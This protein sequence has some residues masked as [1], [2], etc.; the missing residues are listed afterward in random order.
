MERIGN[1]NVTSVSN[2]S[3]VNVNEWV[4]SQR[5]KAKQRSQDNLANAKKLQK[6]LDAPDKDI[7]FL[8][9]CYNRLGNKKVAELLHRAI[10]PD[11]HI[12]LRYFTA[13]AKAQPEMCS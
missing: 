7:A 12:P 11:V 9:K 13:A 1:V 6:A 5:Q 8:R 4:E 10:Q 2:L 3:N